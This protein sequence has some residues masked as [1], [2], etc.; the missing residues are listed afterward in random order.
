MQTPWNNTIAVAAIVLLSAGAQAQAQ[1]ASI[2][3]QIKTW[4]ELNRACRGGSGDSPKTWEACNQR[5]A[6]GAI[7]K[8]NGLCQGKYNLERFSDWN[9]DTIV[10]ER[11]IPCYYKDL[12][13]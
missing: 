2:N 12:T 6:A 8:Q 5:E 1:A 4:T 11:W 9:A 7:L 13:E 3:A 10:R